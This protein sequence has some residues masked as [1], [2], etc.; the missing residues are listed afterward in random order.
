[1]AGCINNETAGNR[2]KNAGWDTVTEQHDC[3]IGTKLG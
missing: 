2:V 1:M 3:K